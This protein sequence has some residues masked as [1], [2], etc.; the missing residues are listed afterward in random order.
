MFEPISWIIFVLALYL[1]L[2]LVNL[3]RYDGVPIAVLFLLGGPVIVAT[4][5]LRR[6]VVNVRGICIVHHVQICVRYYG[7]T[8]ESQEDFARIVMVTEGIGVR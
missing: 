6:V 4:F 2:Y 1:S 3:T 8:S 5:G 7:W